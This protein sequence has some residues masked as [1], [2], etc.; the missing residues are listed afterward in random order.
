MSKKKERES[1]EIEIKDQYR[2]LCLFTSFIVLWGFEIYIYIYI[3]INRPLI[4]TYHRREEEREGREDIYRIWFYFLVVVVGLVAVALSCFDGWFD[5]DGG[6]AD[7]V[8]VAAAVA[9]PPDAF[10]SILSDFDA[11]VVDLLLVF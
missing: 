2:V 3:F 5:V 11:N 10:I 4:A 9:V 6:V 8:V 7:S 1:R